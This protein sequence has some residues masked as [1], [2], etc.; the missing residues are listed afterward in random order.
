MALA[1]EMGIL[2]LKFEI[3]VYQAANFVYRKTNNNIISPGQQRLDLF[4]FQGLL[5]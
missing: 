2:Q 3:C 4:L 1:F 5:E